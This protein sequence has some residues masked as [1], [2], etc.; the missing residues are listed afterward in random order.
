M[1]NLQTSRR[2]GQ[3]ALEDEY[4]YLSIND[5]G[6]GLLR[7]NDV[8]GR[9][10][11]LPGFGGLEISY[12]VNL[13]D[14]SLEFYGT[15][16]PLYGFIRLKFSE[17]PFG[18]RPWLACPNCGKRRGKLYKSG[19][20]FSCRV[21]LNITYARAGSP[22]NW[23]VFNLFNKQMRL[24]RLAEKVKRITYGGQLTRRARRVIALGK[25]LQVD[26][27]GLK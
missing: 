18:L 8:G 12:E 10:L 24:I 16:K 6:R 14:S 7:P 27:N 4:P 19:K 15:A 9:L 2:N 21:C 1:E 26:L 5:F 3:K 20:G 22:R 25:A 13:D 23:H 17:S 11:K